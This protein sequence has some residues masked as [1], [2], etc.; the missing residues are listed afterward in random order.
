[1]TF[2]KNTYNQ[3]GNATTEILKRDTMQVIAAL[4]EYQKIGISANELQQVVNLFKD[5]Y[6]TGSTPPREVKNWAERCTWHVAQYSKLRSELD[7]ENKELEAMRRQLAQAGHHDRAN[8]PRE[9]NEPGK[10]YVVIFSGINCPMSYRSFLDHDKAMDCILEDAI[11]TLTDSGDTGVRLVIK[12]KEEYA[13]IVTETL[14][15]CYQLSLIVANNNE[16]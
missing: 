7:Q 5:A 16:S 3:K 6:E 15:V 10:E 4:A 1:M 13:A 11:K 2:W 8:K 12:E 9:F 14:D